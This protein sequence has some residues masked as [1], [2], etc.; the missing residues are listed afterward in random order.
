MGETEAS[1]IETVFCVGGKKKKKNYSKA[2]TKSSGGMVVV[3]DCTTMPG[4]LLKYI[5]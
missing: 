3:G 5:F 2:G 4:Y 1:D